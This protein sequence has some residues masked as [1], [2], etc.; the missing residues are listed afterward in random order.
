MKKILFL[1]ALL[2]SLY[3]ILSKIKKERKKIYYD[4]GKIRN[5]A[6]GGMSEMWM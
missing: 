5:W 3:Y 4:Y 6:A 2:S 1:L